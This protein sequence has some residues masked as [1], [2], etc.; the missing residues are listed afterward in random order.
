MASQNKKRKAKN[1]YL[2][3]GNEAQK[4][5]KMKRVAYYIKSDRKKNKIIKE[6]D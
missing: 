4:I 3:N 6:V 2:Y 1:S 5:K